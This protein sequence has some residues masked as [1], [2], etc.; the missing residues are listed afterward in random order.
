VIE[1]TAKPGFPELNLQKRANRRHLPVSARSLN[2]SPNKVSGVR[3]IVTR[4][5]SWNIHIDSLPALKI[6]SG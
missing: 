5:A 3:I 4:K 6:C 1:P 2:T